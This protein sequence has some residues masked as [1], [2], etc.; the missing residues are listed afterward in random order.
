MATPSLCY[1]KQP[2]T[3]RLCDLKSAPPCAKK[4]AS[5]RGQGFWYRK[6]IYLRGDW[7]WALMRRF[8]GLPSSGNQ[9][10]GQGLQTAVGERPVARAPLMRRIRQ[11]L[12]KHPANPKPLGRPRLRWEDNVLMDA[13]RRRIP[14]RCATFQNRVAWCDVCDATIGLHSL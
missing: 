2:K 13:G 4:A 7:E 6:G 10:R 8:E 5:F 12:G 3:E 1:W 11:A 9:N 14:D